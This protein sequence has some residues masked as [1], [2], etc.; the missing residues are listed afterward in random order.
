MP[1]L[2]LSTY[3][4]SHFC[5]HL[6]DKWRN[7]SVSTSS[8]VSRDKSREPMVKAIVASLPNTPSSATAAPCAPNVTTDAAVGDPSNSSLDGN[9]A[10]RFVYF[11]WFHILTTR[12]ND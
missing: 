4:V 2:L 5:S 12:V 3:M 11:F 10:P 8:Q 7:L 6:Q 1:A 9:N